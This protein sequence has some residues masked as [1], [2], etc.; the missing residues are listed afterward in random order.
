MVYHNTTTKD[1]ADR[2]GVG[3]ESVS[4]SKN[5]CY[6]DLKKKPK[7]SIV[8]HHP[9]FR[10]GGLEFKTDIKPDLSRIRPLCMISSSACKGAIGGEEGR[11]LSCSAR[12]DS[13]GQRSVTWI[14]EQQDDNSRWSASEAT[15]TRRIRKISSSTGDLNV[16]DIFLV[17]PKRRSSIDMIDSESM[18][19]IYRCFE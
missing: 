7:T 12:S 18:A 8:A 11:S 14:D 15:F 9:V 4:S 3:N 1:D 5:C 2:A 17:Q 16:K 13:S 10:T 19:S 6:G